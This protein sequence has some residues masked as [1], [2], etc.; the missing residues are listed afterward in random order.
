M[1]IRDS[2]TT[3][4][5]IPLAV[6]CLGVWYAVRKGHRFFGL[7]V[8]AAGLAVTL[9]NFLWLIPH[10]APTGVEPFAG[11]YKAVGGTPEGIAHK[12]FAD[13]IAFAHAVGTGH[14]A[15]YLA[16]LLVPFLGLWLLEPLLLLGAVPDL[17]INLLSSDGNQTSLQFQYTAGVVPFLVAATI[18]GA[19]R[20]ERRRVELSLWVLTGVTAI[21]VFS[22]LASIARDVRALGSPQVS[23]E[24]RAISLIPPGVP[25]S[26]TNKLGSHLSERRFIYSFPYVHK[27]RWIVIDVHDS[28][29]LDSA[30][31]KR[32]VR[33]YRSA[34]AWHTVYSAQGI[35]V[36]HRGPLPRR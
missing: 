4:E 31:F 5:E 15:V 35:S 6:G 21:A 19:A 29:Y 8:F 27:S 12:L 22:P 2:F 25:V 32:V 11:R 18:F 13:P 9:F 28:T 17:A 3:K 16:L 1:C 23:A 26:A 14:K 34:E 33:E 10:F 20:F 36:L 7:G 30:G 24:A